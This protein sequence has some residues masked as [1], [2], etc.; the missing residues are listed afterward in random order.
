MIPTDSALEIVLP[1]P[2]SPK[3]WVKF[4]DV[5]ELTPTVP[6]IYLQWSSPSVANPTVESTSKVVAPAATAPTILVLGWVLNVP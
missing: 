4:L 5:Y 2:L 1:I 3:N 6:S